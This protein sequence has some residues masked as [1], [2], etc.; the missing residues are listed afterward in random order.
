M[1]RKSFTFPVSTLVGSNVSNIR[2]IFKNHKPDRRYYPKIALTFL[3]VG[4]LEILILW[5]RLRWGKR[6]RAYRMEEPPVF[7]IGFWRSGTTLLHNLLCQ[8]RDA[9]YTTT[10]QTV[11]PHLVLSQRWWLK[12]LI[13]LFLPALRPFDNVRMD[14]DFPQEEEY[15]LVNVQP[16]SL[17]NFFQFPGDFDDI[18][19]H[20]IAPEKSSRQDVTSWKSQY[21]LLIAKAGINTGGKR[22]IGKNPC[23]LARIKLLKQMFPGARFIFIYRNPYRVVES[24]YRF[25]LSILPGVQLQ[26]APADFNREKIVKLYVHMMQQYQANK[27]LLTDHNLIEI[28]MEDFLKDKINNLASIY[29]VFNMK[30]FDTARVHMEEYLLENASYSRESYEVHPDTFTLVNQYA[31]DIVKNL[32]YPL[33]TGF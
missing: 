29:N 14:M 10:M 11:F 8:D 2:A 28:K 31:S 6:I 1:R 33:E 20:E 26:D 17:Y 12:P 30:S 25:Y 9:S 19:E 24:L 13:N 18:V 4:V 27:S 16:C 22:Y 32:G 5:E 21:R 7:I 15:G 3:A 23:N